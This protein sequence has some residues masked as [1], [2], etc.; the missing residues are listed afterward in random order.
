MLPLRAATGLAVVVCFFSLISLSGCGWLQEATAPEF[1]I[2]HYAWPTAQPVSWRTPAPDDYVLGTTTRPFLIVVD[3]SSNDSSGPDARVDE[4]AAVLRH[5]SG[6]VHSVTADRVRERDVD[7]AQAVVY[8]G[9]NQDYSPSP[10]T[11]QLLGTARALIWIGYHLRDAERFG[12]VLAALEPAAARSMPTKGCT[13]SYG[14]RTYPAGGTLRFVP[15]VAHYP[16]EALANV[17]CGSDEEPLLVKQDSAYF[18]ASTDPLKLG[19]LDSTTQN[20]TLLAF[21]DALN[22]AVGTTP[23]REVHQSLLELD[24][25]SWKSDP[26]PFAAAVALLYQKGLPYGISLTPKALQGFRVDPYLLRILLWAQ[27]HGGTVFVRDL[28]APPAEPNSSQPVRPAALGGLEALRRGGIN[29]VIWDGHDAGE[30][31]RYAGTAQPP[32][33]LVDP[34]DTS[35]ALPWINRSDVSGFAR[36]PSDLAYVTLDTQEGLTPAFAWAKAILMCR[37]CIAAAR[38][39]PWHFDAETLDRYI[40]TMRTMDYT[41]VDPKAFALRSKPDSA[42]SSGRAR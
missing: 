9:D 25:F 37:G 22:D 42:A 32:H 19:S 36:S 27:G 2:E 24:G 23:N 40:D 31:A 33:D 14:E 5:F 39:D 3:P 7:A 30:G 15:V 16:A 6:D 17:Q 41:F 26:Q 21:A 10:D 18:V 35:L 1:D 34:K 28:G 13:F 29:F 4:V 8:I 12:R 38:F 11:L 20:L